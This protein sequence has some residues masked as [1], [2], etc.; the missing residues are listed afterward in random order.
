MCDI[1]GRYTCPSSCPNAEEE[2][3]SECAV[4]GADI[5]A[6]YDYYKINDEDWCEECIAEARRTAGE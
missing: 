4:C 5:M 1:C 3:I 2:K 6:G